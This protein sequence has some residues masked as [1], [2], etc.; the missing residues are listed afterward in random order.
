MSKAFCDTIDGWAIY[1]GETRHNSNALGTKYGDLFGS[2]DTIGVLL[3]MIKGTLSFQ[4]NGINWGVAFESEELWT[5]TL[6]AA[7]SPIYIKDEYMIKHP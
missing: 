2:G 4:K 3:D 1:N 6:Y 7:V 5:G